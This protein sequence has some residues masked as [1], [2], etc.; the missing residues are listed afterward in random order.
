MLENILDTVFFKT[1][2]ESPKFRHDNIEASI[3]YRGQTVERVIEIYDL[4]LITEI[5]FQ[6]ISIKSYNGKKRN[7]LKQQEI[8]L[9]KKIK[10]SEVAKKSLDD[11]L[12]NASTYEDEF[13]SYFNTSEDASIDSIFVKT[14]LE[15]FY[16]QYMNK[17]EY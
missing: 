9:I 7:K 12:S 6:G 14:I 16:E 3:K 11:V 8:L 13:R 1:V 4:N 15:E 10:I 17:I 2:D 5:Y